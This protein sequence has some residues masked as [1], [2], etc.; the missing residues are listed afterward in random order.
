M[1]WVSRVLVASAGQ[2]RIE[3]HHGHADNVIRVIYT[4]FEIGGPQMPSYGSCYVIIYPDFGNDMHGCQESQKAAEE[5][6]ICT[7]YLGKLFAANVA[8]AFVQNV[9]N[10]QSVGNA[11]DGCT[12]RLTKGNS[13]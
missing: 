7:N 12:K 10:I 11:K 13:M 6:M 8:I 5:K 4:C 1:F 3:L 9:E 2:K